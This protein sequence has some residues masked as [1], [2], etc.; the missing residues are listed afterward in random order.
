VV[1]HLP[2]KHKALISSSSTAEEEG[3]WEGGGRGGEIINL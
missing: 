3:K 1:E 2:S